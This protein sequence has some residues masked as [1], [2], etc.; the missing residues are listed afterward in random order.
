M[1]INKQLPYLVRFIKTPPFHVF[2]DKRATS[3]TPRH[4][5]TLH[6][7]AQALLNSDTSTLAPDKPPLVGFSFSGSF[8]PPPAAAGFTG[9]VNL[10]ITL[11]C[12]DRATAERDHENWML[13]RWGEHLSLSVSQLGVAR[14]ALSADS[15]T[16]TL[17]GIFLVGRGLFLNTM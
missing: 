4:L 16:T 11:A 12:K 2:P 15:S 3:N 7:A 13:L 9:T 6:G 17:K 14:R 5:P 8:Q 1:G 10:E